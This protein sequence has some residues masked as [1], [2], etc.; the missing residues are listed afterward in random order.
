MAQRT[1]SGGDLEDT[2]HEEE[3]KQRQV[4]T[5]LAPRLGI[6]RDMARVLHR[7]RTVGRYHR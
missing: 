7:Y 3:W 4:D 2:E 5:V 6:N 1:I